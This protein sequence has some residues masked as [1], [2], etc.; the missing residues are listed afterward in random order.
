MIIGGGLS[1]LTIAH[2]LQ[3][4]GQDWALIEARPR[5]GGRILDGSHVEGTHLGPEGY[6]MGPAWIWPHQQRIQTLAADLDVPLMPQFAE[7]RLVFQDPSG[8]IQRDLTFAPMAGTLRAVGGLNALIKGLRNRLDPARL[9]LGQKVT[10]IQTGP[11]VTC[12][13]P[14]GNLVSVDAARVVL[15]LPPRLASNQIDFSGLLDIAALT[16]MRQV[17]TWM[18]TS[19]KVM[20]TFE[21]PF[22]RE[23]G[24][25]GDAISHR[26]PLMEIH[27]ASPHSGNPGALFGFVHPQIVA[28]NP[29]IDALE[30]AVRAQLAALFGPEAGQP[31]SVT[32]KLWGNDPNTATELDDASSGHPHGGIPDALHLAEANGLFFAGAEVSPEEPGLLEG[33]IASAE[34]CLSRLADHKRLSPAI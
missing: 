11:V 23:N 20:A 24:L 8:A 34:A 29:P 2:R 22:W 32:T 25:S 16:T 10:R 5:L 33:A 3:Q 27:D 18:A 12:E 30:D 14:D 19:G 21:T 4:D 13:D 7:G 6:D 31:L 1:G 17:P 28:M 9:Y 15:A 26:G